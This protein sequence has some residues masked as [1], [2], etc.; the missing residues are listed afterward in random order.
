V[1]DLA[2]LLEKMK[3]LTKKPETSKV[4]DELH[5]EKLIEKLR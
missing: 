1:W 2:K 4:S 3:T 5:I